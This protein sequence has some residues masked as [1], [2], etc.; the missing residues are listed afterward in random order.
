MTSDAP[1]RNCKL[2]DQ[3]VARW[4]DILESQGRN[5]LEV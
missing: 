5:S 1:R 3:F 4:R 2:T